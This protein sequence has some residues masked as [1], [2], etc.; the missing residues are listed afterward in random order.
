M[1]LQS[2]SQKPSDRYINQTDKLND[3]IA[4]YNRRSLP[5][6]Y[7]KRDS[8][9]QDEQV[10]STSDDDLNGS[11]IDRTP[12]IL[13]YKS[14]ISASRISLKY[15]SIN[16]YTSE[17][18]L[19]EENKR[20]SVK[21]NTLKSDA[22]EEVIEKDIKEVEEEYENIEDLISI[23]GE[24]EELSIGKLEEQRL[25]SVTEI[26]SNDDNKRI[27]KNWSLKQLQ[28]SKTIV[29][30]YNHMPTINREFS[31]DFEDIRDVETAVDDE[32][33]ESSEEIDSEDTEQELQSLYGSL[34]SALKQV[35]DIYRS[36]ATRLSLTQ[37]LTLIFITFLDIHKDIAYEM[38]SIIIDSRSQLRITKDIHSHT[39]IKQKYR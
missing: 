7:E 28:V 16:S 19:D 24:E 35:E 27:T 30:V 10:S 9:D 22:D 5:N 4:E 17:M 13:S 26:N 32:E 33:V 29:D 14:E 6:G 1:R 3:D 38:A 11:P 39:T 36:K 12:S 37:E 23:K 15:S 31:E 20:T 34:S 25:E 8:I 18:A 21:N 2:L